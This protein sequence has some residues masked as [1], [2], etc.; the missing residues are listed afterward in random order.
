MSSFLFVPAL[1]FQNGTEGQIIKKIQ[2]DLIFSVLHK[3][4]RVND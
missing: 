3:S 1:S 4:I 2:N